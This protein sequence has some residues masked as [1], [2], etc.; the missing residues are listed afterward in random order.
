MALPAGRA[1]RD[2][3]LIAQIAKRAHATPD[4]FALAAYDAFDVA[5]QTLLKTSAT[6]DGPTLRSAFATTAAAFAGVTGTIRL[7]PA[8]DRASAPYAFWSICQPKGR[9]A[10]W[11]RTGTWIPNGVAPTGRGTVTGG[12]CPR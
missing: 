9:K 7:D 12:S 11:V 2:A 8:G 4:A 1:Q 6:V 3:G 10:Q 5:V